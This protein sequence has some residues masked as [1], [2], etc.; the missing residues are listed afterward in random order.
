MTNPSSRFVVGFGKTPS[1]MKIFLRLFTLL[2]F[3][4]AGLVNINAQVG[5]APQPGENG[6]TGLFGLGITTELFSGFNPFVIFN[7]DGQIDNQYVTMLGF[8]LTFPNE[9]GSFWTLTAQHNSNDFV[10]TMINN[11]WV[12][13][14]AGQTWDFGTNIVDNISLGA[15]IGSTIGLEHPDQE[16]GFPG[17]N[18]SNPN[19]T[20]GGEFSIILLDGVVSFGADLNILMDDNVSGVQEFNLAT[21]GVIQVGEG[22]DITTF[23]DINSILHNSAGAKCG[24]IFRPSV[25]AGMRFGKNDEWRISAGVTNPIKYGKYGRQLPVTPQIGA[26][27]KFDL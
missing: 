19:L 1:V 20:L 18:D 22:V 3:L 8:D 25:E 9:S 12:S 14:A 7:Q 5:Q 4:F 24:S 11:I 26:S 13:I 6:P 21:S 10:T 27:Y 23:F 2:V 17:D 16:L 15:G